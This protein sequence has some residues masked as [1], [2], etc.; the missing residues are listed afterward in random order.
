MALNIT[1]T[2]PNQIDYEELPYTDRLNYLG[3]I[4]SRDRTDLDIQ[5]RLNTVRNSLNM[6]NKGWPSSTYSTRT[7]M[8]LSQL[9]PHNSPVW[10]RVLGLIKTLHIS[11]QEPQAFQLGFF[12]FSFKNSTLPCKFN[13]PFLMNSQIHNYNTGNAHSFRLPLCRT[14]TRLFS[15]YFKGPKFCNSLNS[16]LTGSSSSASFRRKFK[17][18]FLSMYWRF[19]MPKVR[20]FIKYIMYVCVYV[21][22][23]E[24]R[25]L[26]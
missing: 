5:C 18:F 22:V 23:C 21:C 8:K 13:N 26:V 15:F 19:S 4:I 10:F 3:S 2:R 20:L 12:M 24:S 6:M 16:I 1:N 17:E 25:G 11:H 14:K 9:C 7:K